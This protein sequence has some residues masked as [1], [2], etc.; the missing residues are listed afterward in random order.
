V[1]ANRWIARWIA[2]APLLVFAATASAE[3]PAASG[4]SWDGRHMRSNFANRTVPASR[5]AI[6]GLGA[7]GQIAHEPG[8]GTQ[9]QETW[10]TINPHGW[11]P[12]ASARK[13]TDT[14]RPFAKGTGF[15]PATGAT[16]QRSDGLRAESTSPPR[17]S[18]RQ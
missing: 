15:S 16:P 8:T 1:A 11:Q 17:P 9:V 7:D 18:T 12:G 10:L 3:M 4:A 13:T 6:R 5:P 14:G 2:T